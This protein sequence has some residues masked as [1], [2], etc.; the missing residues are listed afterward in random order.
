MKDEKSRGRGEKGALLLHPG[1]A[2]QRRRLVGSPA[3]S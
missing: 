1:S 2:L 3:E